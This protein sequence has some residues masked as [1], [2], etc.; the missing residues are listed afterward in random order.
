MKSSNTTS[1]TDEDKKIATIKLN[2]YIKQAK[3]LLDDSKHT[4]LI[5]V[6]Q[7]TSRQL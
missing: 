1:I 6:N 7:D 5:L 2:N 4:A 3:S